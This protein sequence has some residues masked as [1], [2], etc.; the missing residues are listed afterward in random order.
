MPA[1]VLPLRL[2]PPRLECLRS[3]R[4]MKRG[5]GPVVSAQHPRPCRL[6]PEARLGLGLKRATTAAI[7]ATTAASPATNAPIRRERVQN[8]AP[9][10]NYATGQLARDMPRDLDERRYLPTK[11][12]R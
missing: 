9:S 8:E 7:A 5:E 3:T 11:R 12:P 10:L 1:S 2:P 4:S 6:A